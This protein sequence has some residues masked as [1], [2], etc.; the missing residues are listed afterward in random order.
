VINL[1]LIDTRNVT[2][3]R[4]CIECECAYHGAKPPNDRYTGGLACCHSTELDGGRCPVTSK[5]EPKR[6]QFLRYTIKWRDFDESTTLP[7]EVIS[8]DA[9]DNNSRWSDFDWLP[10]G[11][12]EQHL[13]QKKDPTSMAAMIDQRSGD[14]L[15][16]NACH[17][18][19]YIPP[20]A[21]GSACVHKIVNSW[22][23]PYPIDVVF[24]RNHFHNGGKNMSTFTDTADLCNGEGVYD[25]SQTLRY[26]EPCSAG[27]P[28][29]PK[30]VRIEQGE[31]VYVNA[32]YLQDKL[33]HYGAMAM[34]FV[35]AH[36]P[37]SGADIVV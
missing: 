26:I 17:I 22:E 18:E 7:L 23:M 32:T 33:P 5:H 1:H 2:D 15:Q 12:K 11:Y 8:F 19:Y 34:S 9:T 35:Y 31:R 24:V 16:F 14:E 20:C 21:E 13:A 37:K 36:I 3:L 27:T 25:G 29:L 4:K 10:G 28:R 30:P 6:S